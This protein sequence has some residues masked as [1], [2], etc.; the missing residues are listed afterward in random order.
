M[1]INSNKDYFRK[2]TYMLSCIQLGVL[3]SQ[4]VTHSFCLGK[5]RKIVMKIDEKSLKISKNPS[6]EWETTQ[7]PNENNITLCNYLEIH[8][9]SF[10][11]WNIYIIMISKTHQWSSHRV[12][13][14]TVCVVKHCKDKCMCK[15]ILFQYLV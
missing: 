7:W 10:L 5:K 9:H 2:A 4:V 12:K 15:N 11:V 8:N 14:G 3:W 13:Q 6:I 1:K